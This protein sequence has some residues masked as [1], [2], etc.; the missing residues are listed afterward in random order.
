[1]AYDAREIANYFITERLEKGQPLTHMQVQKLIYAAHGWELA[2]FNHPLISDDVEAWRFG[3]VIRRVFRSLS[4]YGNRPIDNPMMET[5]DTI[6]FSDKALLNEILDKYAKHSG[7]VLS[8]WTH[9][10]GTPWRVTWEKHGQD[11]IIP[12]ELIKHYFRSLKQK[13]EEHR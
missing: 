8:N 2:L 1:M 9:Q 5:C 12:N 13:N 4:K 11:A 10:K 7:N 3:P 6:Q